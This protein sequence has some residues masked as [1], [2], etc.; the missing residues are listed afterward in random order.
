MN[1][2][3]L[4]DAGGCGSQLDMDSDLILRARNPCYTVLSGVLLKLAS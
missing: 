2:H 4:G 1:E 3:D